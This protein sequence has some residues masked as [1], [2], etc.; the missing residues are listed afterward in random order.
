MYWYPKE[1]KKQK[2]LGK[3]KYTSKKGT[4]PHHH[5]A[6]PSSFSHNLYPVHH[7]LFFGG[8]LESC[9]KKPEYSV[10]DLFTPFLCLT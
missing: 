1:Q 2:V 3:E 9:C 7:S 6:K 4:H 5:V 8:Y 10:R